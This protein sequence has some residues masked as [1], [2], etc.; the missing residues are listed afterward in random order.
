MRL[1]TIVL[2]AS[3]ALFASS[4]GA[5][6]DT[7]QVQ[8]ILKTIDDGMFPHVAAS[9]MKMIT[10][11]NEAVH[12]ELAM[13]LM[14]SADNALIG[15]TS[16][17]TDKGKYILKSGKNLWMY[18]SDVKR[19]IRLSARDAFMGTDASNYDILQLNL[20]GDY[21]VRDFSETT[22]DGR[23]VLKVELAARPGTEG[24]SR[25]TSWIDPKDQ[26]LIKNDCY[27]ISG[28]L[29][30]TLQYQDVNRIS[31]F[32]VPKSVLIVNHLDKDR[33]TR[34]EFERVEPRA[35]I[36]NSIF[37]LGYLEALN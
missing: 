1:L 10:Y 26:R 14:M 30:K 7:K 8:Q 16:P 13:E 12:K 2:A 3:M 11:R 31:T 15:I 32:R 18:F 24:Y 21:D 27:S 36:R 5:G 17:A 35:S 28:T 23:P 20:L 34:I 22:L 29:I 4:A 19:S 33:S 25:I 6:L 37:T 9:S